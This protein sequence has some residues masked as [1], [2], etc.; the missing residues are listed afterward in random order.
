MSDTITPCMR[1]GQFWASN[2]GPREHFSVISKFCP[3]CVAKL[4][5]LRFELVRAC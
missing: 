5:A 3:D 4:P 1:C 2:A